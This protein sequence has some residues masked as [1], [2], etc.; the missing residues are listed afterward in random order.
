MIR[1]IS[2]QQLCEHYGIPTVR[3]VRTMRQ[4]GL[5]AIRLGK[6]YL[7]DTADVD[8]FLQAKKT[9]PAPIVAPPSNGC[10]GEAPSTSSGMSKAASAAVARA[11]LSADRLKRPSPRLSGQVIALPVG[12]ESQAN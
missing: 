10:P 1:L 7:Y 6:A 9:C 12:R 11:L 2:A 5:A 3:T 4:N 8:A